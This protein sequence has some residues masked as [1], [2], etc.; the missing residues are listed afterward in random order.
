MV[1]TVM[2][3]EDM[4]LLR[5]VIDG[6]ELF[7]DDHLAIDLFAIDRVPKPEGGL[8]TADVT[9]M[10]ESTSIYSQNVV[11][12]SGVNA[13]GKT[14]ALNLLHF[15]LD[16]LAGEVTLRGFRGRDLTV[17]KVGTRLFISVVFWHEEAF[18]LL[19]SE[20]EREGRSLFAGPSSFFGFRFV[21]ET[22]WRLAIP[23]VNR[24]MIGDSRAFREAAVVVRRRHGDSALTESELRLLGDD[25]SIVSLVT[26]RVRSRVSSPGRELPTE[27]L[28]TPV[29]QAFDSSVERLDWDSQNEVYTLQFKGERARIVDRN[30]AAMLLS[31]GTVFGSEMVNR[32]MEVLSCGGYLL[33]DEMEEAINRSL[34]ATIID[35]FVSPVTNPHGAQLIF[36]THYPELLDA[37][38]RKDNIYLLVRGEDQRTEVVKYSDRVRRIENKK[39]EVVLSDLIKGTMPRYPDVRA[40]RDYVKRYVDGRA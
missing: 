16:L 31:R 4:R 19:E 10:G 6:A 13:S 32:A 39:S 1:I 27:T 24:R 33:V 11:G 15:V 21:D 9:Q 34:V 23:R 14:T 17:G 38:H 5:A 25:R 2:E 37:L 18:Y 36:T 26:G 12:I 22:I 35:L 3:G 28:A 40:M 30:V 20:L 7:R 8:R 29:V